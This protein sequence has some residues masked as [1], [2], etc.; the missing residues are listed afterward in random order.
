MGKKIIPGLGIDCDHHVVGPRAGT[1]RE[2]ACESKGG[3][4]GN[5]VSMGLAR[6]GK[7]NGY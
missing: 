5:T 6:L 3:N 7:E 2:G 4:G 1:S